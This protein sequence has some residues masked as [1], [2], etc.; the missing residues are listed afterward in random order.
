MVALFHLIMKEF[1]LAAMY[2]NVPPL[3]HTP[4]VVAYQ[5]CD[6]DKGVDVRDYDDDGESAAGSRLLELLRLM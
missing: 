5:F 6:E 2:I 4:T 3:V 1:I